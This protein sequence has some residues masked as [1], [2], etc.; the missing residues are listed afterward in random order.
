MSGERLLLARHQIFISLF[1]RNQEHACPRERVGRV[2]TI[3][4]RVLDADQSDRTFIDGNNSRA[5]TPLVYFHRV[6]D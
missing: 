3:V 2:A 6:C 1:R 5:A 4:G